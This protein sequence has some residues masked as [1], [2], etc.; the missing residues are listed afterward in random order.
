[1]CEKPNQAGDLARNLNITGSND[2]FIGNDNKAVTWAIKHFPDLILYFL[3]THPM[4]FYTPMFHG[5]FGCIWFIFYA[6]FYSD[7]C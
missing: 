1:M 3:G 6:F 4:V 2:G 5:I 7:F